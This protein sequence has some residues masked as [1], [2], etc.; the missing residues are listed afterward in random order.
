MFG[1]EA[2][3]AAEEIAEL[4][5]SSR[6]L[7]EALQAAMSDGVVTKQEVEKL[8]SLFPE[9]RD[10]M[11]KSGVSAEE[12]AE[13][14]TSLANGSEDAESALAELNQEFQDTNTE[15]EKLA[16]MLTE[17]MSKLELLT[18]AQDELNKSGTL[19]T[20]TLAQL[21][22]N[23]EEL[24]PLVEQRLAGI[25]SEQELQEAL[26]SQYNKTADEYKKSIVKK[27]MSNEEFYKN[28]VLTNTNIVSKLAELG[29][30]DLNNYKTLEE[31]KETINKRIQGEMTKNAHDGK[32][33]RKKIYGEEAKEFT[34]TQAAMLAAQK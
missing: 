5:A 34:K 31:L 1:R 6:D 7:G 30:T 20:D 25:I 3:W 2:E 32:D 15:G 21:A 29:I 12:V 27:M 18:S 28:A 26:S 13:H 33:K 24:A 17:T 9:L 22:E 11:D 10:I 16:D 19:S 23:F 8:V 14:L 4:A